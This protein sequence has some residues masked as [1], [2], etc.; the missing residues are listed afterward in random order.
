MNLDFKPQNLQNLKEEIKNTKKVP[1][2]LS[3][4]KCETVIQALMKKKKIEKLDIVMGLISIIAQ[5]GGTNKSAGTNLEHSIK[6]H[7]L[8]AGEIKATI[9][10]IE[11]KATFRQFCR[12]MQNEIQAY[13][14]ELE[15]EGDL[16]MQARNDMPEVSMV[17]ATWCSNFQ[18][19]NPCCP[20]KIREWLKT[21]Q[22]NRFNC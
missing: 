22:Q 4:A 15:I 16:S 21:N 3:R 14:Q 11:P 20:K 18:T 9:K 2:K 6:N 19:D 17:E 1:G 8:N 12:E 10:E 13:A 7:T 5:S